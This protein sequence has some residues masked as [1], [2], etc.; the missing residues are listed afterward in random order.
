MQWDERVPDKSGLLPGADAARI[1]AVE[2]DLGIELPREFIDFLLW[3]DG[4]IIAR[5][6]II[7]SA[8]EGI[9]PSETLLKAN[10]GLWNGNFPLITVGSDGGEAE[11][12][13]KKSDLP[14]DSAPVYCCYI[15]GSDEDIWRVADSFGEFV[16]WMFKQAELGRDKKKSR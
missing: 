11:F 8:G 7:Y 6:I 3:A 14:A 9:H 1:Q 15:D 10:R 2:T 16:E 5:W 12:G 13:F 4:G